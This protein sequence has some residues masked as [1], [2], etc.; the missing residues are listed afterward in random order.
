MPVSPEEAGVTQ[1]PEEADLLNR[2]VDA[3]DTH[4]R[5]AA[6]SVHHTMTLQQEDMPSPGVLKSLVEM[7]RTAGTGWTLYLKRHNGGGGYLHIIQRTH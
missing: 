7:Y 1:S 5:Q 2:L 3:I 6:P 4:L